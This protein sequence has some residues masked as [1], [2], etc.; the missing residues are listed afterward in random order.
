MSGL[1]CIYVLPKLLMPPARQFRHRRPQKRC[2]PSCAHRLCAGLRRAVKAVLAK[3]C[4]TGPPK[5]PGP[6]T[7][8]RRAGCV[9]I[10]E[11]KVGR[12]IRLTS[13]SPLPRPRAGLPIGRRGTDLCNRFIEMQAFGAVV[14]EG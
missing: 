11:G 3:W 1:D 4:S 12:Y 2:T 9:L 6:L 7:S 14:P 10:G 13:W 8:E 5:I